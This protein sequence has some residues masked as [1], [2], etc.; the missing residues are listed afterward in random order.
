MKPSKVLP[1]TGH[2][3]LKALNAFSSLLLGIKMLPVYSLIS[4]EAFY[5]SF[6]TK[7][8]AEKE[9]IFRQAIAFVE[10][11]EDEINATLSFC[12]DAN[13]VPYSKENI[14]NL[15]FNELHEH[16]VA[17]CMEISKID[18][19]LVSDAEKKRS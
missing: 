1:L 18:I 3:S 13:G 9:S 15:K 16:L 14:K 2:K 7:S 19:D 17:V 5:E 8:E 6:K 10:L 4:Y 11:T 12:T